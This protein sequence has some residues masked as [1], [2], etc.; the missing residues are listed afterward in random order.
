MSA[1]IWFLEKSHLFTTREFTLTNWNHIKEIGKRWCDEEEKTEDEISIEEW[2]NYVPSLDVWL[3]VDEKELYQVSQLIPSLDWNDNL[4]GVRL[5]FEPKNLFNLYR[6]FR[7]SI[8]SI[9][10]IM[11]SDKGRSKT[12]LELH[13][14]D[15]WDFLNQDNK[16]SSYFEIKY[17]ILNSQQ[18]QGNDIDVQPTPSVVCET[19]PLQDIIKIDSIVA[20]REFSDPE[21]KNDNEI[22]T[23]SRQ[24]QN[25]YNNYIDPS[26]GLI[27]EGD[28]DLLEAI[29]TANDEF[30]N[31]LKN[32]FSPRI[33][34]L[35]NI[36]YPGFQNPRIEIHSYVN[37]KNSITHDS[38]VQ[39]A[40]HEDDANM[41][42]PERYNGL[43]YRNLIS[44][45]FRLIQFRE[46][47][48]HS[49][50]RANSEKKIVEPIHLVFI[51][52]PEAHLH[53]QAQQVFIRKALDA[54]RKNGFL[55]NNPQYKTQLVIS[56]H[57]NHI[58]NEVDMGCLRYFQRVVDSNV[59]IPIS[60][61]VNLSNIFG[62]DKDTSRFVTRYIKLT[63]CDLFFADAAILVE[64]AGERILMP[65]FIK[66]ADMNS[67][68]IAVIEIN[69][70]H[71]HR[72]RSLIERLGI[73]TLVVTDIDSQEISN[74]KFKKCPPA[75]NT[76]QITNNDTLKKWL[77]VKEKVDELLS[78]SPEQKI[79][80]NIRI[81]YQTPITLK[82][83]D[84]KQEEEAIPY[85]FE[86]S[87]ALTNIDLF[88]DDNL[89]KQGMITTFHNA[90]KESGSLQEFCRRLFEALQNGVKA[91]F[92]INLLYLEKFDN[93]NTPTYINEGLLWI[94]EKLEAEK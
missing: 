60:K 76:E 69:G 82:Y 59:N 57:S 61:V 32:S 92:A 78:L 51:E 58:V 29:N 47:W 63:H 36:N 84:K 53:A 86:D 2:K 21:G 1:I 79:K 24:L 15:L 44:M 54:L 56:T 88:A 7:E 37:P 52:E 74:G 41:R 5:N 22:D 3:H 9:R 64:G 23:L 91:E 43:G 70:S 12:K 18:L 83:K 62:D 8:L 46:E 87:I 10:N 71:A 72:F 31:K 38:A 26:K 93:L 42:L 55:E 19:N 25:Y 73:I 89:S 16:L 67:Y 75:R 81:A 68:Y 90:Y 65:Q 35:K 40:L 11:D 85:T 50:Q 17:Y 6:T 30:D 34:E 49:N 20:Q 27:E 45:Y 14:K 13:P 4:M 28:L 80:E 39:F 66:R 94:K 77:P 48:T 33:D